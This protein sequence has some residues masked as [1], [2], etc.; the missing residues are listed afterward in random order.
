M[1]A[2][3][4]IAR[5]ESG[6]L[7][8]SLRGLAWLMAVA[9][10][11]SLFGLLL[12]SNTELSLLDNAQ[13]V[14]DMVGIVTALGGLL[15]LVVGI[16]AVAGERER[17]S[18]VPLLLTPVSR[19]AILAGKLGGVAIAW[20]VMYVLALPYLWAVGSTGQNL[21]QG[22]LVLAVVGSPVVL[23]FGFFGMILGSRLTSARAGLFTGLITLIASASPLLLGPSL[24][25]SAIGRAFDAVNPF[26]AA[27][28]A[29]DAVIIDSQTI[30]SQWPHIAVAAVWIG[31]LLWLARSAFRRI[32]R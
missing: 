4:L 14:Y 10:S 13:V 19:D 25:Q 15:S 24:R 22:M 12:V 31:L 16:D 32:A 3:S 27:V 29:Y 6:E 7:L 18:L 23:G 1:T 9:V 2:T 26:S 30:A 28:N 21:I 8:L 11:L 20:A 17:G 5:K